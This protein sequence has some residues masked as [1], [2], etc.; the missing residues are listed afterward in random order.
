MERLGGPHIGT[1]TEGAT[2]RVALVDD[3]SLI[4]DALSVVLETQGYEVLVPCVGSDGW[5]DQL[6]LFRPDVVLLDLDLGASGKGKSLIGTLTD[7]G[8]RVVIVS[9]TGDE[10]EIGEALSLGAAG[11]SSKSVSFAHLLVMVHRAGAGDQIISDADRDHL[12]EQWRLRSER[13]RKMSAPFES[14]TRKESAVLEALVAGHSVERIAADSYVSVTTVR[15]HIRSLFVKLGVNS[16]LEAV[17][18][19]A[20]A[21]WRPARG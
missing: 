2:V 19:A 7:A 8:A 11:W 15:S 4:T 20:K 6:L 14:L 10:S 1:S 18:T 5:V 3:H 21:N 16:Q 13:A 17:A 12:L 9:A